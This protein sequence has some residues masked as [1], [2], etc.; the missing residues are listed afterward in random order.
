MS[1]LYVFYTRSLTCMET[2]R[3]LCH[4]APLILRCG[5]LSFSAT[6]PVGPA[7]LLLITAQP[8]SA[9]YLSLYRFFQ[10]RFIESTH[11]LEI[12]ADKSAHFR[13]QS[14]CITGKSSSRLWVLQN[15]TWHW[16]SPPECAF[17]M[18]SLKNNGE[19][20]SIWA[21][22][23]AGGRRRLVVS[24]LQVTVRLVRV[25][26]QWRIFGKHWSKFKLMKTLSRNNVTFC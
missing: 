17:S 1:E 22:S 6:R 19:I 23:M 9:S 14:V 8:L 13:K 3:H 12:F 25:L 15:A 4:L 16:Q 5:S 26:A 20:V 10:F 7:K 11:H 18:T 24:L 21:P 2:W